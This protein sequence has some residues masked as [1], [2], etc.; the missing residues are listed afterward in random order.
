MVAIDDFTK[1]TEV[2]QLATITE[3]KIKKIIWKCIVSK[4]GVPKSIVSNN[5]KQFDNS[6][7]TN[8]C[9]ELGIKN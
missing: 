3:Q 1:W 4:F 7:F 6:T 9:S 8:F 5:G 2:D